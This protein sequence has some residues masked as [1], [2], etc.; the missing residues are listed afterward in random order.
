[1]LTCQRDDCDWTHPAVSSEADLD[2]LEHHIL[3]DCPQRTPEPSTD[4]V[5]GPD[6]PI[7]TVRAGVGVLA[8]RAHSANPDYDDALVWYVIDIGGQDDLQL[9]HVEAM[10][11]TWPIVYQP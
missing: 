2:A 11:S 10:I 8:I 9:E 4:N 6:D 7:G 3:T 1:M 5:G